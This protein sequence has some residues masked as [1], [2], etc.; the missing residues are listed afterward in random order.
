MPSINDSKCVLVTG[1][2]SGIGRALALDISKLPSKPRVIGSGR[3]KER[4]SELAKAGLQTVSLEVNSEF[5]ELKKSVEDIIQR[6]PDLD[7]VILN[8]GVQH[9]M[10]FKKDVD[11]SLLVQEMNINYI[12][13]VA[14]ITYI[15]PHFM[16]LTEQGR[17][18]FIIPVTSG[19]GII[20]GPWVPTYSATKAALH[21]FST[22]LRAQLH[23]TNIH[24]LEIIPPLVESELHDAYGTTEKLSKSWMP[25]EEFIKI[26]M[27]GLR[28]GDHHIC[29]GT[30]QSQFDKFDKGKDEL[31]LKI[32]KAHQ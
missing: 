9:E 12:S 21:S 4:L 29:P 5:T 19:L 31:A 10:D 32:L 22:S 24:I 14:M 25:L 13:V 11:L 2:T 15:L 18:C 28:N 16:K 8:A 17:P 26:T 6:Y 23:D 1:A 20:P 7:T 3:R 27:K 30:S